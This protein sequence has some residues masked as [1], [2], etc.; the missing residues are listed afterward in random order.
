MSQ[1]NLMTREAMEEVKSILII[2]NE[3][4]SIRKLYVYLNKYSF[5]LIILLF[6]VIVLY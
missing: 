4:L 6:I 2:I 3:L 5:I 1:I